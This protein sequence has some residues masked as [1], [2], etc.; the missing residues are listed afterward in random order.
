MVP[1]LQ[2]HLHG[3]T[4]EFKQHGGVTRKDTTLTVTLP[5]D[6]ELLLL[7]GEDDMVRL[8]LFTT[9]DA[10]AAA[11]FSVVTMHA[12]AVER[13]RAVIASKRAEFGLVGQVITKVQADKFLKYQS[14]FSARVTRACIPPLPTPSAMALCRCHARDASKH[15]GLC[16]YS[17]TYKN[18]AKPHHDATNRARCLLRS[19]GPHR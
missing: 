13:A 5:N 18:V 15:F 8:P 19:A 1:G 10:A 11:S 7:P 9:R 3:E 2:Y 4:S 12:G 17:N 14:I 6:T 16:E